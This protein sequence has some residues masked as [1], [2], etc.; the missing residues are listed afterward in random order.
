[1]DKTN[2]PIVL[3]AKGLTKRFPGVLANDNINLKLHQGE[4]LALLGENGAGKST[5]M[6]ML[7]GLYTPTEGEIWIKGEKV[8]LSNPGEAIDRG[9]GMVH[10]HFQLVPPMTVAENVMLGSEIT[11]GGGRLN[12]RQ[13][14]RNVRELSEQY[15]L[16]VDPTAVIEDLPVG[17]QQR[18]EII[19]ALYRHADILI[20]DEPTAVLTPQEAN[21]LF[22]IMRDLTA[23]NVSIIFITH[24]L[25]EVLA[26]ADR[27]GVLRSGQMV[28]TAMPEDSTETSL[29]EM[30]VG[31]NVIL[32][33]E[34]SASKPGQPVLQIQNLHVHDDRG[35]AAVEGVDLEVFAGEILGIAGV[36]GNGQRELVEALTGLRHIDAG[37]IRI[38]GQDTTHFSPRQITELGVAHIPEDREKHG[39]VMPYTLSDNMVLNRYFK[40]PYA[41]GLIMH[42][43]K[44]DENGKVLVKEYDV[45]PPN[46]HALAQNLSGGNKQ[47]VIVA[48]EF[49]S[50]TKLLVAAQ[51]TRGIDVGSIEFIHKEIVAQRDHGVAVLVVSA[52]LDEVLGLAD[53]VAVMF[54]GRVVK[55]LP[56]AEATRER[57]GLLMAGSDA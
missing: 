10:Q 14:I 54:D 52:E 32:R 40:A 11:S 12:M 43:D 23:Q 20:L 53:R 9:V 22:R 57:V 37:K 38:D 33:V 34:K 36:E 49:S 48:R 3:E 24:K 50:P 5:L 45:R 26:V 1:M 30:M 28:G 29:A 39:L 31:R 4:I 8:E 16:A 18:V 46:V 17:T 15:G 2:R 13:A 47:K 51:P 27:I 35:H 7:Y 19:K 56:I 6:N 42:H 41:K 44:I 21:E 25:K 55:I